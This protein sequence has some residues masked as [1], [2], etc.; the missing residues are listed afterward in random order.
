[1]EHHQ[2][3]PYY[4][5]SDESAS[6]CLSYESAEPTSESQSFPSESDLHYAQD[7]RESFDSQP[8]IEPVSP[9]TQQLLHEL[10]FSDSQS[11]PDIY[12]DSQS[13][14]LSLSSDSANFSSIQI[15]LDLFSGQE[16]HDEL[17]SHNALSFM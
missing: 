13:A 2:Q 1:M 10:E 11:N 14:D 12:F 15:D 9:A 8:L 6:P 5:H 3:T 4:Y 7:T 16:Y 17:L